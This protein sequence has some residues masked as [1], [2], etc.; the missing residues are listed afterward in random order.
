VPVTRASEEELARIGDLIDGWA[1]E[2][3]ATNDLIAAIDHERQAARWYVRMHGLEKSTITLWLTLG[4]RTLRYEAYF[5]PGP[6]ERRADCYEYLL[7]A[8]LSMFGMRFAIGAED[9]VYLVGQMPVS[10]VD[11]EELDR[12]TG[13]VYAY[14]ERFFAP[15][16]AIGYG[17]KFRR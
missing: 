17:S 7:R 12:I 14:S 15:A 10:A 5:M 2:E 9:A 16:M 11:R 6:E 3:Q 1:A 8:N 13:A 4:E